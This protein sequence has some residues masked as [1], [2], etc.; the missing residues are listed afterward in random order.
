MNEGEGLQKH[1]ALEHPD[2]LAAKE[3]AERYQSEGKSRLA[4][5][6]HLEVQAV[7]GRLMGNSRIVDGV[8]TA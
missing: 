7:L 4:N 3:K 5:E 1:E 8:R 2:Y 6:Q